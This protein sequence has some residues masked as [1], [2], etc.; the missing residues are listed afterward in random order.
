[1]RPPNSLAVRAKA[2]AAIIVEWLDL[3]VTNKSR[4]GAAWAL[5]ATKSVKFTDFSL[6]QA[7]QIRKV[8]GFEPLS[9]SNLNLKTF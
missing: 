7:V 3:L 6:C 5:A 8:Y 2:V 4:M 1:M 9:G